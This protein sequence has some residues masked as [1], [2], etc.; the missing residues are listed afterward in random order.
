M[1]QGLRTVIYIV[2]DLDEAKVWY[3]DVFDIDPYFDEPF[4]VGFKVGGYELGLQPAEGDARPGEGGVIAY[5]G[6]PDVDKALTHVLGNGAELREDVQEVG[7]G[8]RVATVYDPFGNVL[9]L[10]E[11]PHFQ[12]EE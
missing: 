11:N 12:A 7:E 6:V 3:S 9:G 5:W 8:V 10:I 1:F 2:D 4:Y